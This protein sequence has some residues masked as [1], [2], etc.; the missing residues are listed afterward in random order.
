MRTTPCDKQVA[1]E[2]RPQDPRTA[3]VP[4]PQE[5]AAAQRIIDR[6]RSRPAAPQF[7]VTYEGDAIMLSADHADNIIGNVLLADALATGNASFSGGLLNQIANIAR[8][9]KKLTDEQLNFALAIVHEIGPRD[10]T[11]ALLASQMMAVH[12]ATMTAAR[13]LNHC[14]TI[15]QQDSASNMLNKLGRTFAGQVE[16]L[17]R[18]RTGGEQTVRVTHQHVTVTAG[19]AVVGI[20]GG[21]GTHEKRD[22]CHVP[23]ATRPEA[24]PIGAALLGH[25]QAITMPLPGTGRK[26]QERVQVPRRQGGSAKRSSK[27]TI[28]PRVDDQGDDCRSE[29]DD[30]PD[31]EGSEAG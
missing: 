11:E 1:A 8:Q 18:Y 19:Q 30:R 24:P 14:E 13:R 4:K 10:P 21:G 20:Q 28:P 16:A 26:G 2:P 17:R 6:R 12:I 23:E 27:W 31:A 7:K 15:P 3:Y 22:Q 29:D 5:S 9:G 25:E